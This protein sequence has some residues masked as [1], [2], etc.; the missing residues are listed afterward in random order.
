MFASWRGSTRTRYDGVLGQWEDFCSQRSKNPLYTTIGNVLNF[1]ATKYEEGTGYSSACT[2]RAALNPLVTL[3]GGGD[4]TSHPLTARLVKGVFHTRPPMPKYSEV[5]DMGLVI[6]YIRRLG[7]NESLGIK[8][9]TLK[10]TA[11]LGILTAQRVSSVA[12]FSLSHTH[13]L[14]D[15]VIFVPAKLG[16]HHRQ[17][18]KIRKVAIKAYPADPRV[19][20]V[21]TLTFYLK[22]RK[23]LADG[24]QLLITHRKPHRPASRDSVARWLRQMLIL[25]GVNPGFFGAHSIEVLLRVLPKRPTSPLQ[26]F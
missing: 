22:L 23:Q 18:K 3:E 19:C 16:K 12:D 17:G 9:L 1:L 4:I 8:I 11:L 7:S 2:T 24:D 13:V 15:R 5:W 6:S 21:E 20:A 26:T 25:S 14:Q 10:L